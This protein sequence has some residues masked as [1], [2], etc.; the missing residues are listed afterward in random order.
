MA[1]PMSGELGCER[2]KEAMVGDE[3]SGGGERE[4]RR[5]REAILPNIDRREVPDVSERAERAGETGMGARSGSSTSGMG[6]RQ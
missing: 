5:P 1:G 4:P 6:S 3:G 2:S